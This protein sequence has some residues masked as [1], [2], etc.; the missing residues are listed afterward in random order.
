M[1]TC[2]IF[3]PAL[4]A[5]AKVKLIY[6]NIQFIKCCF[7]FSSAGGLPANVQIGATNTS[8][9]EQA[10]AVGNYDVCAEIGAEPKLGEIVSITCNDKGRY[11][12]VQG[13]GRTSLSICEVEVYGGME[14]TDYQYVKITTG[15]SRTII[16]EMEQFRV[17]ILKYMM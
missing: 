14:F 15:K 17:F 4:Y 2:R 12:I 7:I 11:L 3:T 5:V 13:R 9:E 8:P 16:E 1:I 10:P 6:L